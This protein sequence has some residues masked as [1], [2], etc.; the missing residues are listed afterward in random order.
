MRIK[1]GKF[2]ILFQK[3]GSAK[4][5]RW[6]SLAIGIEG[7]KLRAWRKKVGRNKDKTNLA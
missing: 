1:L 2:R 3:R 4:I 5:M 7:S 6:Y